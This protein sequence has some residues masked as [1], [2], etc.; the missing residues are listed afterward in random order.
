MPFVRGV[1]QTDHE[2]LNQLAAFCPGSA[3][4]I[5]ALAGLALQ[6][7]QH[8]QSR[9]PAIVRQPCP[10]LAE[11]PSLALARGGIGAED[12]APRGR[13]ANHAITN[14]LV[15]PWLWVRQHADGKAQGHSP[16]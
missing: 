2:F 3:G 14:E 7:A 11:Q 12:L 1:V 4:S 9:K 6:S 10:G 13:I 5:Q 15:D 16:C 8:P